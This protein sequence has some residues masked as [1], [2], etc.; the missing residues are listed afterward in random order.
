MAVGTGTGDRRNE[1]ELAINTQPAQLDDFRLISPPIDRFVRS[2]AQVRTQTPLCA[3]PAATTA[4]QTADAH[5]PLPF[6]WYD[7][8]WCT[9]PPER[10]RF[11]ADLAGQC[12]V[13][14]SAL[15]SDLGSEEGGSEGI[16]WPRLAPHRC[17]R[18]GWTL[19]DAQHATVIEL[20]LGMNR[21][22]AGSYLY[23]AAQMDRWYPD[24]DADRD[25]NV[26][27]SWIPLLF[28]PEWAEL[29]QMSSKMA[30]L[31]RLSQ[32]AVYV[33]CDEA[34]L[35]E[36]L[37]VVQAARAD[38]VILRYQDDPVAPLQQ[39][40][41]ILQSGDGQPQPRIWLAGGRL[42]PEDAV[43]CFALGAAAV[44]ID[45]MCNPWLLDDD[46]EHLTH[47]QRTAMNL[48]VNVGQS[49]EERLKSRVHQ[50]IDNWQK[51][52]TGIVQSLFVAAVQDLGPHH[53][54]RVRR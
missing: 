49:P 33:S 15:E 20:R 37:P 4:T 14:I 13:T 6:F 34:D 10:C 3:N 2:P 45:G 18:A 9:A 53:L 46:Q 21:D 40:T 29:A 51:E 22:A 41:A 19:S 12:G 27:R 5:I 28:P 39:V 50:A 8:P 52:V 26:D 30:Q 48:G 25:A 38:G 54:R 16:G 1:T 42:S 43:K 17:D 23:S 24:E 11:V 35:E 47:A 36:V 31:R 32:A 7:P 44:A